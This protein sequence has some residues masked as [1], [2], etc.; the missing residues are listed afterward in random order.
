MYVVF[1]S[2]LTLK[3][4]VQAALVALCTCLANQA[5]HPFIPKVIQLPCELNGGKNGVDDFIVRHGLE[6]LYRLVKIAQSSAE[7]T[8]DKK[9]EKYFFTFLL[10]YFYLDAR[11]QQHSLRLALKPGIFLFRFKPILFLS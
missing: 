3:P 8:F 1:D 11:T 6:A 10:F 7:W 5:G 9:E 4:Q 2:D